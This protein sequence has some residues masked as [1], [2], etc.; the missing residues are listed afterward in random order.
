M[1][2]LSKRP[3]R[4]VFGSVLLMTAL[5]VSLGFLFNAERINR[6][7]GQAL[8]EEILTQNSWLNR[9]VLALAEA[10]SFPPAPE[11]S[12]QELAEKREAFRVLLSQ[13]EIAP[14]LPEPDSVLETLGEDPLLVV[15]RLEESDSIYGEILEGLGLLHG[16]L[17]EAGSPEELVAGIELLDESLDAFTGILGD[18]GSV[19]SQMEATLHSRLRSA[20][21]STGSLLKLLLLFQLAALAGGGF[22]I[23]SAFR[24]QAK[25][26]SELE[27]L[28]PICSRCKNVR[29]DSGYW[30]RVEAYMRSYTHIQFTHGL[31]PDCVSTLYPELD[32][33]EEATS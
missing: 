25:K 2:P 18:R 33:E 9:V 29:D 28:I 16:T 12:D 27:T 13:A 20:Q 6:E 11:L 7:E 15:P 23:L 31:C 10:R 22:L 19:V 5:L 17:T 32:E 21:E 24:A 26:V 14:P 1:S 4:L 8:H 30:Q 3:R